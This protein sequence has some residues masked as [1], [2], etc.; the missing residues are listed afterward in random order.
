MKNINTQD[1]LQIADSESIDQS[2]CQENNNPNHIKIVK[3]SSDN[4]KKIFITTGKKDPLNR[5]KVQ[6]NNENDFIKKISSLLRGSQ[7]CQKCLSFKSVD[8]KDYICTNLDAMWFHRD[9]QFSNFSE[10]KFYK[11][12]KNNKTKNNKIRNK[13]II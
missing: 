13:S 12:K 4:K 3:K 9:N 7:L 5:I 2:N 11:S 6:V 1:E 10:C 8:N